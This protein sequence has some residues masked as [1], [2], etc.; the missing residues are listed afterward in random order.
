M[1]DVHALLSASGAKK[2]LN[3]PLS[4]KMEKEFPTTD[5][6]YSLEGTTAHALAEA[7]LQ[8]A[9]KNIR[10][11]T[12]T[13]KVN[14]LQNVNG[15]MEEYIDNYRDFVIEKYNTIRRIEL[16]TII[17]IEKRVDFSDYAPKG[18]GTC[19]V[20]IVSAEYLEIIDLKYGKGVKVSAKDN[21]QL[22]L[23]ALGALEEYTFLYDIKGINMTIYQPRMNTISEEFITT[24]DLIEWG[25]NIVKP[26]AIKAYEGKGKC[27]A[28]SHCDSGFCKARSVCRAYTEEKL[29]I[30]SY[31]YKEADKLTNEEIADI[32]GQIDSI[33][34][35][36][37]Q[38]KDYA[39][40]QVLNKGVKYSGYKLV[41]GKSSRAYA[42]NEL[43]IKTLKE[44]GYTEEDIYDK[45]I[46]A[47]TN[48]EK[49]LGKK[50]FQEL[51]GNNI[52]TSQG[53]PVLAPESDTRQ[54]ISIS[55]AEEDFKN[56]IIN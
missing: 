13:K 5:T 46:K 24:K 26:A 12:Y 35:W 19:D 41:K 22:R 20:V 14:D 16:D 27:Y 45:K 40:N 47:I 48:M 38:I 34:I 30:K 15:E 39:Y 32:L 28:G 44:N 11:S 1:P 9:L 36:I 37:K 10:R 53:A 49:L 51:I 55:T 17:E 25:E 4:I 18:F 31:E 43:I 33:G 42:D 54:E 50:R 56:I 8:L 29:K 23:Y 3:C 6:V 7:K 52:I 2:W 21:P